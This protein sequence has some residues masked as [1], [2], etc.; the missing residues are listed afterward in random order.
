[1]NLCKLAV[2]ALVVFNMTGSAWADPTYWQTPPDQVGDWFNAANWSN[3][4]PRDEVYETFIDNGGTARI[5]SGSANA[6]QLWIGNENSGRLIL[7][8]GS[9]DVKYGVQIGSRA[10]LNSQLEINGGKLK[11][12][13]LS[14][15]ANLGR[16]D[17]NQIGGVVDIGYAELGS[18]SWGLLNALDNS[19]KGTY[20][21]NGG[22]FSATQLVV[23]NAGEGTFLQNGGVAS[24]TGPLKVGGVLAEFPLIAIPPIYMFPNSGLQELF[25]DVRPTVVADQVVTD[26]WYP[27]PVPSKGQ[28]EISGGSLQST[29]VTIDRTGTFRQRGGSHSTGFLSIGL[30]GKYEFSGGTLQVAAGVQSDGTFDFAHSSAKLIAGS[31]ILDF[32]TGLARAEHAR[33]QAGPES[34][35][36]FPAGFRPNRGLGDYVTQGS[37]HFAGEELR[38]QS[39]KTIRGAGSIN[40]FVVAGGR[41]LAAEGYGISLNGGINLRPGAAVDLREGTVSVKD[42]RTAFRGGTLSADGLTVTGTAQYPSYPGPVI[43]LIY[44]PPLNSPGLV[45][46]FGGTVNIRQVGVE[47]GAY[48]MT[49]GN[50]SSD[51]ITIGN[52]PYGFS[53]WKS[54]GTFEQ[55]GGH[56]DARL[57]QLSPSYVYLATDRAGLHG[58]V[59]PDAV[60]LRTAV[61]FDGS[62]YVLANYYFPPLPRLNT[63]QLSGGSVHADQVALYESYDGSNSRFVQTGGLLDVDRAIH[64][65]GT[66]SSFTMLGGKL[67][68]RRLEVGDAYG[69]YTPNGKLS[70]LNS[71]SKIEVAG[72]LFLGKQSKFE[73]V[74]G[75]T[76]RFKQLELL[77][78]WPVLTGGSF[79]IHSTNAGDVAGLSNVKAIFEGGPATLEAAGQDLGNVESAFLNNFALGT[80]QVGGVM[81]AHL[82]L[83][84]LVDNRLVNTDAEAVYVD[85][86]VVRDGS[87][88]DL[89]SIHLYYRT[90]DIAPNAVIHG[91][92]FST[93]LN[94]PEPTTGVLIGIATILGFASNGRRRSWF[95]GIR[96]QK[97][98][99]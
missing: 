59:Q 80:L 97:T 9:L 25:T 28:Y 50:L 24:V 70:L 36:I 47:N 41:L 8:G 31:S 55:T 71:T 14:A 93:L 29:K 92:M 79:A 6:S 65:S 82:S 90:A 15:S 18:G 98:T 63:Y 35:T 27:P 30:D 51:V 40:D 37:T 86:L 26:I 76:I 19:G 85:R 45:R 13:S 3:G 74:P 81:S 39:T 4:V 2:C 89:G 66:D 11:S 96:P 84:D 49:G 7:D 56:V 46:Q 68:T 62:Q 78:D 23:G 61:T 34:L 67:H 52:G 10:D 69:W 42:S 73:A 44:L 99:G 5:A 48:R 88:L 87:V 91:S 95:S 53:S 64:V 58:D 57:L 94:T 1:M 20:R 22:R 33:I 12:Q 77:D 38:I 32:S 17:I 83:V 43:P 75:T 21:L 54:G 60:T 72:E 16:A